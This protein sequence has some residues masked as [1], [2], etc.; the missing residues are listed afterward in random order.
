MLRATRRGVVL[1]YLEYLRFCADT[2]MLDPDS[3]AHLIKEFGS[4]GQRCAYILH[5][6][7]LLNTSVN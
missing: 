3:V 2:V 7:P 5:L 6:R 1:Q 4:L